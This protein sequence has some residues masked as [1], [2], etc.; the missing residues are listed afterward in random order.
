MHS[1]M[2]MGNNYEKTRFGHPFFSNSFENSFLY[3]LH[4][5]ESERLNRAKVPYIK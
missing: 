3:I 1:Q 5:V 4:N 2:E